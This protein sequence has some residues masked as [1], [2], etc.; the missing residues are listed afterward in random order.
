M[1]DA[2]TRADLV[3]VGQDGL[4][5]IGGSLLR[6]ATSIGKVARLI[7]S[8][9]AASSSRTLNAVMWRLGRRFTYLNQ[10]SASVLDVCAKLRPFALITT[11][12]APVIARDLARLRLLGIPTLNFSTDDPW[13]PT[14][15]SR[16]H[17]D[18]LPLY[19]HVFSP[20]RANMTQLLQHG[21]AKVH[22]LPF[23]YDESLFH[24]AAA[25]ETPPPNFDL[26]FVGGADPAR[27]VFIHQLLNAGIRVG[28]VG[29]YWERDPR[30]RAHSLGLCPPERIAAL[31]RAAK[32]NLCLVRTANRDGHVMRTFEIAACGGCMLVQDT[33]EHREILGCQNAVRYFSSA[34]EAAEIAMTLL[35]EPNTRLRLAANVAARITNGG[36][37]YQDRLSQMLRVVGGA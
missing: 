7:N 34:R 31:T 23:G 5:H 27:L 9:G 2:A 13:N 24:T 17:L 33:E 4:T 10:F 18:A 8:D 3:I 35:L 11:G 28:L 12:N 22:Y 20:R 26:L 14:L 32:L 19:T 29:A 25:P 37:R 36:H 30:T 6:G 1:R 15:R 16:W 21:C